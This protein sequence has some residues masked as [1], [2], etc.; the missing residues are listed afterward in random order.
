MKYFEDM[1]VHNSINIEAWYAHAC[2][3]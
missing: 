3:R 2:E 1:G